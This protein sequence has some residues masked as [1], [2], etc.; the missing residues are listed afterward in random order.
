MGLDMYLYKK[1][2]IGANFSHRKVKGE[3]NLTYGDNN[4]PFKINIDRVS[5]ISE[6]VAY[7]RKSNEIHRWIVEN[8][9]DG[10]DDCNEYWI[11]VDQ[12]EELI[13]NCKHDI[14]YIET[15]QV[16]NDEEYPDYKTF[17]DVDESKLKLPTQ[18][19]FFFG[20][21]SYDIW[22]LNSLKDTIEMLTP[23]LKEVN[24]SSDFYYRSSW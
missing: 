16:K 4:T 15:L 23:L 5:E 22:Y 2:Y 20:S 21:T 6:Q 24:N 3:I 8:V 10:V 12:L 11:S 17:L 18:S 7:W 14:E 9:Q 19:G 13:E 1:T